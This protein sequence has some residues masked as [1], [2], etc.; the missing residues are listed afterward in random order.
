[1][2]EIQPWGKCDK[3]K[4]NNR[5]WT[6]FSLLS[7]SLVLTPWVHQY[8]FFF[9]YP[10][11]VSLLSPIYL[12]TVFTHLSCHSFIA[13]THL[14]CHSFDHFAPWFITSPWINITLL[15]L[16]IISFFFFDS[17][18]LITLKLSLF[19]PLL[20]AL[21]SSLFLSISFIVFS[22]RVCFSNVLS[23]QVHSVFYL[24]RH[25]GSKKDWIS[26]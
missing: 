17:P 24:G 20:D 26:R 16:Y 21:S 5:E 22:T 2:K 9:V 11:T 25:F 6:P 19:P 4:K 8:S 14:C 1:M 12:A 13:F 7:L 3:K 23:K 15:F 18:H 10:A